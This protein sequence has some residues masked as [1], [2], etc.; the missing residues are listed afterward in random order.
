MLQLLFCSDCNYVSEKSLTK[1]HN[2]LKHSNFR[3]FC[4]AELLSAYNIDFIERKS[5][6]R[7]PAHKLIQRRKREREGPLP[8]KKTG[9][10]PLFGVPFRRAPLLIIWLVWFEETKPKT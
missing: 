7:Q 1:K 5:L 6:L 10:G 9:V 3:L 8:P 2:A 4:R